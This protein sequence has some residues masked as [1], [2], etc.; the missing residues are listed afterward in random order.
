VVCTLSIFVR[1]GAGLVVKDRDTQLAMR[2]AE[3][4]SKASAHGPGRMALRMCVR[5]RVLL[6]WLGSVCRVEG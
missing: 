3:G 2:L 5:H 4:A 6:P 1:F